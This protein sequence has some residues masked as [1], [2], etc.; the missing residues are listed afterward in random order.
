MILHYKCFMK[1]ANHLKSQRNIQISTM[2]VEINKHC[3]AVL[4]TFSQ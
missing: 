3:V 1:G 2:P 4:F